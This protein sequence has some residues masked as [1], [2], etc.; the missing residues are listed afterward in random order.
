MKYLNQLDFIKG[1]A[2][3]S[4]IVL[5]SVPIVILEKTYSVFHI[6]Q[7]VPLFIIIMGFNLIYS[8]NAPLYSIN[9][10]YKRYK[11]IIEPFLLVFILS[12]I[13]GFIFYREE[14]YVGWM[15]LIG[16]MPK[17][18]AGNYYIT[19]LIQFIFLAP[20]LYWSFK[21]NPKLT[22]FT[23]FLIDILFQVLAMRFITNGY[24]YSG[25]IFRYF[26]ALSIGM[27][28]AKDFDLKSKSNIWIIA[29]CL[30]SVTYLFI[31]NTF[32]IPLFNESWKTQNLL[33]FF[34]PAVIIL[35][36][37]NYLSNSLNNHVSK[38]FSLL[39]RASYHIFLVQ[40]IYF[41]L[42]PTNTLAEELSRTYNYYIVGALL[43]IFNLI[44]CIS[45]GLLFYKYNVLSLK[46]MKQATK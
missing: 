15:N 16:L 8:K 14:Y 13:F 30:V 3:I 20:I 17:S 23:F 41:A 26:S 5:H 36:S 24:I 31:G 35:I 44:V 34:Y 32:D 10:F 43:V 45:I 18:G 7:A 25:S 6:W 42:I 2:A 46:I 38:L 19:I 33:S 37:L 4:V 21:K 29:G 1:F 40:M 22:I 9:Y 11:R 39:G 28:I 12:L 27:W